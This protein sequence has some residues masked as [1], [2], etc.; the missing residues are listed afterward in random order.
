MVGQGE[1]R[2]K[3][4]RV[5]GGRQRSDRAQKGEDCGKSKESQEVVRGGETR[6]KGAKEGAKERAKEQGKPE[7]A[8]TGRG[9]V[10]NGQSRRTG[11]DIVKIVRITG[12]GQKWSE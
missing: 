8:Q 1:K 9:V 6:L 10:G 11:P 2:W 5:A 3:S 7:S 4:E 12:Q